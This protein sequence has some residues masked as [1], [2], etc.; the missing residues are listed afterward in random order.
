MKKAITTLFI[1]AFSLSYTW[2]QNI[3]NDAILQYSLKYETSLSSE[4]RNSV[5]KVYLKGEQSRTELISNSGVE[6][7]IYDAKNGKGVLLREYSNQKLMVNLSQN[8]WEQLNNDIARLVFTKT[9][10]TTKIGVYLCKR[11]VSEGA[12]KIEVYYSEDYKLNNRNY[13][14]AFPS[15]PGIPVR[16]I[17][18]GDAD[19]VRKSATYQLEKIDTDIVSISTFDYPKSG[20]R[21]LDFSEMKKGN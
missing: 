7:V 20:F 4:Q 14:M 17:I 10:E 1:S 18:S 9:E 3:L 6:T 8:E 13:K 2:S 19:G 21:L 12:R 11:A 16:I 15:L 5:W